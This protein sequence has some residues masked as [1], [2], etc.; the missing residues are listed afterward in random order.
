MYILQ[1]E[2]CVEIHIF[3]AFLIR[4]EFEEETEKDN[5]ERPHIWFVRMIRYPW[6]WREVFTL[7]I[8]VILWRDRRGEFR[9]CECKGGSEFINITI[10]GLREDTRDSPIRDERIE[11]RV[12]ENILQLEIGVNKTVLVECT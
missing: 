1:A 5:T 9:C 10:D 6:S 2:S 12:D 7:F 4:K 3:D 8:I 11:I